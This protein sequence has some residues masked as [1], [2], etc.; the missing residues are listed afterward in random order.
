MSCAVMGLL[1]LL[2]PLDWVAPLIPIL[3]YK[4]IDFI[5][6]PVPILCGLVVAR[7]ST[8]TT[9]STNSNSSS[10]GV[11]VAGSSESERFYEA[12]KLLERC[13]LVVVVVFVVI[14]GITI[15]VVLEVVIESSN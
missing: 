8:T 1:A 4:H 15:A 2:Q 14:T 11:V 9:T 13:K 12:M 5:E 7:R 3:P 10:N 6:S